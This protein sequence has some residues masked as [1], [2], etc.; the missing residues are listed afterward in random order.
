MRFHA[1]L[2]ALIASCLLFA[3][4]FVDA[5]S[6]SS[7]PMP[8]EDDGTTAFTT[9]AVPVPAPADGTDKARASSSFL[10]TTAGV[11]VGTA[12]SSRQ[13][14]PGRNAPDVTAGVDAR[15]ELFGGSCPAGYVDCVN[16]N[17]GGTVKPCAIE[18]AGKCCVGDDACYATTACIKQDGS[19]DGDSACNSL[20]FLSSGGIGGILVSGPSCVGISACA[21]VYLRNTVNTVARVIILT[22]S[23]LCR[24]SCLRHCTN[25]P[26][27]PSSLP[28]LPACG[29]SINNVVGNSNA[30][31]AVSSIVRRP[32]SL[33]F[34]SM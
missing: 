17:V 1:P 24:N 3:A 21:D 12:S 23:C 11:S 29:Q 25:D 34:A 19:C 6:P 31:C 10:R 18:C 2:A 26:G 16:G 14:W 9:M 8:M 15:R 28:G 20:G 13:A 7:V 32:F 22:N 27:P 30:V 33:P 5:S 4:G